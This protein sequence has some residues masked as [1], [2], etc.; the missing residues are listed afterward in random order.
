MLNKNNISI[1]KYIIFNSL[2]IFKINKYYIKNIIK[3]TSTLDFFKKIKIY[4]NFL[5]FVTTI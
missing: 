5:D 1:Y 4:N 2:L 3:Y